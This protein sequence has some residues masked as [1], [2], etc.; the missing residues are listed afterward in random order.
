M[1]TD[2]RGDIR[3]A[4]ASV[5]PNHDANHHWQPAWFSNGT[6]I[7]YCT[8]KASQTLLRL[9]T[10]KL[11]E[12]LNA[13]LPEPHITKLVAAIRQVR[14]LV[15]GSRSWT[16]F[17]AVA[18]ALLEAWHDAI[19]T[20]SED[21]Q[22][23]VVHGDCPTGADA[24]AKQWALDNQLTHEPHPAEWSAPCPDNC[25]TIPHRKTST[26]HGEYCPGAGHR[27][28]QLM[29]DMGADLMVAFHLN[30]SRGTAD[31]IS[32]AEQAG[33]PVRVLKEQHG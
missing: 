7:V 12:K 18:D 33:I 22:L 8:S 10:A 3:A 25:L 26:R 16:D 6:L 20:V 28:N 30:N 9:A 19:Q 29:V 2:G 21:V 23:V 1:S 4:W 13:T 17:Q 31:C 14:V 24:M 32:R 11:L 27:R 5:F 15:T